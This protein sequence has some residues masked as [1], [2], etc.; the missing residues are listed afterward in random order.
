MYE[1][2]NKLITLDT[3][4]N[5][6]IDQTIELFKQ[7]YRID[8]SIPNFL[9]SQ[10]INQVAGIPI[11]DLQMQIK[12]LQT[13]SNTTNT[14]LVIIAVIVLLFLAYWLLVLRYKIESS[15]A[16]RAGVPYS[17]VGVTGA[18]RGGLFG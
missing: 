4:R 9:Q 16:R 3:L 17:A 8:E 5:N 13:E 11:Q 6:P 18:G 14:V 12:K 1:S 15:A 2:N 10:G 7:G